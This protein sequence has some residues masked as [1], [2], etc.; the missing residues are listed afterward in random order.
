[1]ATHLT[2]GFRPSLLRAKVK[3]LEVQQELS[4]S[5]EVLLTSQTRL[6]SVYIYYF[7]IL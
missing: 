5:F 3:I 7:F 1:M 4:E 6:Y 2:A